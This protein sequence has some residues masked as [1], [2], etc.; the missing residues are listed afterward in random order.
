MKGNLRYSKIKKSGPK[1]AIKYI[2]AGPYSNSSYHQIEVE[3]NFTFH[4]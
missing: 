3:C 2:R 4:W 1:Q